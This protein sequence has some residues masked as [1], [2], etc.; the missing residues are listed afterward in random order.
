MVGAIGTS[1]GM[2]RPKLT[3]RRGA[4]R[5]AVYVPSC[6]HEGLGS[7]PLF[8]LEVRHEWFDMLP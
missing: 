1:L 4:T 6:L 7:Y 8:T 2:R 3:G 5:M